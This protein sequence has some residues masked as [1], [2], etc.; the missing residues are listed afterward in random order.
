[1]TTSATYG[2]LFQAALEE[3]IA[4]GGHVGDVVTTVN[5]YQGADPV[6]RRLMF[7]EW[8]RETSFTCG[9]CRSPFRITCEEVDENDEINCIW[10]TRPYLQRREPVLR[11]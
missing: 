1:M 6:R 10:C 2:V 9:R 11:W 5:A 8:V 3:W 7:D 4:A